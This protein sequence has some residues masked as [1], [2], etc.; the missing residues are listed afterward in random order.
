MIFRSAKNVNR[1][2]NTPFVMYHYT[3]GVPI[4]R[5]SAVPSTILS[6]PQPFLL[7][8]N[9]PGGELGIMKNAVDGRVPR[10]SLTR[11]H[12]LVL[13]VVG[14]FTQYL[15]DGGRNEFYG[16]ITQSFGGYGIDGES[17][18]DLRRMAKPRRWSMR[19]A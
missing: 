6:Q 5:R 18:R 17:S 3:P 2:L 8:D 4:P 14:R 12:Q 19:P 16:H 10:Y 13:G 15:R 11:C 1:T 9:Q 7:G